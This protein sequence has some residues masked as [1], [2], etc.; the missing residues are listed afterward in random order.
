[1]R[2]K[3]LLERITID[4]RVMARKPVIRGTWLTAEYILNLLANGATKEEILEEYK[5]FTQE[6]ICACILFAS[7]AL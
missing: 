2:D 6:D 4:S 1:M 7:K 3:E 5:G